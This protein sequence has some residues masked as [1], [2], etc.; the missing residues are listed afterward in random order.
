MP[1]F[2]ISQGLWFA[3]DPRTFQVEP[4]SGRIIPKDTFTIAT[5]KHKGRACVV[6]LTDEDLASRYLQS[7]GD[8]DLVKIRGNRDGILEILENCQA[9]GFTYVAFDPVPNPKI[10]PIEA[11]I[12]GIEE[13]GADH[14]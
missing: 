12:R 7:R 13:G 10:V 11:V 9:G 5:L 1:E 14:G 6:A 4:D 8:P 3:V 2:Y